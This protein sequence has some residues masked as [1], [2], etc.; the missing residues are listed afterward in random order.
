MGNERK[1]YDNDELLI[2]KLERAAYTEADGVLNPVQ[3]ADLLWRLYECGFN[4]LSREHEIA[5]AIQQGDSVIKRKVLVTES[6]YDARKQ[7]RMEELLFTSI[8]EEYI[9]LKHPHLRQFPKILNEKIEERKRYYRE[10]IHAIYRDYQ[11][12]HSEN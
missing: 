8:L 9:L 6:L 3:E 7:K 1:Q 11:Q 10:V 4:M 5:K 12:D 2:P